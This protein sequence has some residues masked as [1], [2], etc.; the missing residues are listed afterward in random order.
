MAQTVIL[1]ITGAVNISAF[2]IPYTRLTDPK[3]RL[4]QYLDS[5]EYAIEHYH[6]VNHIVFCENTGYEY[7]YLQLQEKAVQ[8]GKTLEVISFQGNYPFIETKGKGYGEGEIIEYALKK[9][10]TLQESDFFYKLTGRIIVK[11]MDRVMDST[12]SD[13]TFIFVADLKKRFEKGRIRTLLYKVNTSLYKQKLIDAY[14][15]VD[16]FKNHYLEHAF[17][18][19]LAD[20]PA[21][22]FGRYPDFAGIQATTGKIYQSKLKFIKYCLYNYLGFYSNRRKSLVQKIILQIVKTFRFAIFQV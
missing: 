10:K 5:L 7:D 8:K 16:D 22:S 18:I 17:Y 2:K 14:T 1:L 11:N 9:S 3:V 13:N 21:S 19:R 15:E 12:R 20:M 4:Q 6:R